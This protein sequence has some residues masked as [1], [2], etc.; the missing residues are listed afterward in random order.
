MWLTRRAGLRDVVRDTQR[1]REAIISI[2][3]TCL[4]ACFQAPPFD[5]TL[6]F[7]FCLSFAG[8]TGE[9]VNKVSAPL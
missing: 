8:I 2:P 1:M 3:A 6:F 5:L 4:A 9:D 7:F